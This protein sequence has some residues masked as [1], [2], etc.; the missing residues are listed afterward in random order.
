LSNSLSKAAQTTSKAPSTSTAKGK[1]KQKEV[2]SAST[3][4]RAKS[5]QKD[6]TETEDQ[7]VPPP[8]K[9]RQTKVNTEEP[10]PQAQKRNPKLT[11]QDGMSL[12]K[13]IAGAIQYRADREV[14]VAGIQ[15]LTAAEDRRRAEA[16]L[17]RAR[18]EEATEHLRIQLVELAIKA[19]SAGV[20][21]PNN[22]HVARVQQQTQADRADSPTT[23]QDISENVT[24]HVLESLLAAF[25]NQ[26]QKQ[27]QAEE[28]QAPGVGPAAPSAQPL[29][30]ETAIRLGLGH[31]VTSSDLRPDSHSNMLRSAARADPGVDLGGRGR[32]A[33]LVQEKFTALRDGPLLDPPADQPSRPAPLA[34]P[35]KISNIGIT[36]TDRRQA[37]MPILPDGRRALKMRATIRNM[38]DG[39]A[40]DQ[41][42]HRE[43]LFNWALEDKETM[44][45]H[46]KRRREVTLYMWKYI[47]G[48][49]P[50]LV[51]EEILWT[52]KTVEQYAGYYLT[53]RTHA[54]PGRKGKYILARTL[55]EWLTDLCWCITR[56]TRDENNFRCGLN[57]LVNG[58]Y[59]KL[60]SIAITLSRQ[61]QLARVPPKQKWINSEEVFMLVQLALEESEEQGRL[62]KLQVI[63]AMLLTFA[64]TARPSTLAPSDSS[65]AQ[66]GL[67]LKL[68]DIEHVRED[69]MKF[70]ST[71]TFTNFKGHNS[72]IVGKRLIFTLHATEKPEF[73]LLSNWCLILYQHWRGAFGFSSLEELI[74]YEGAQLRVLESKSKEPFF[75]TGLEGGR[76]LKLDKMQV[77]SAGALSQS[78]SLLGN[79]LGLGV[80][81]T[82]RGIRRGSSNRLGLKLGARIASNILAHGQRTSRTFDNFYSLN[83]E[84]L[85]VLPILLDEMPAAPDKDG[86]YQKARATQFFS[87][88]AVLSIV[89]R[90]ALENGLSSY[91]D[92]EPIRVPEYTAE[93]IA[94]CEEQENQWDE[95]VKSRQDLTVTYQSWV[96]ED[97]AAQDPIIRDRRWT[98]LRKRVEEIVQT[99]VA[100]RRQGGLISTALVQIAKR[101]AILSLPYRDPDEIA[102]IDDLSETSLNLYKAFRHHRYIHKLIRRRCDDRIF[103]RL[104]NA[105]PEKDTTAARRH[106]Q[107]LVRQAGQKPL[108]D[109]LA[110]NQKT[111]DQS[112]R[113]FHSHLTAN[114]H[115]QAESTIQEHINLLDIEEEEYNQAVGLMADFENLTEENL[116]LTPQC[117]PGPAG[118]K[119]ISLINHTRSQ[120]HQEM[121]KTQEDLDSGPARRKGKKKAAGS[122]EAEQ[123]TSLP[124]IPVHSECQD[125]DN[126]DDLAFFRK[127]NGHTKKGWDKGWCHVDQGAAPSVFKTV[128]AATVT[129]AL[130]RSV[131]SVIA[132]Q[133]KV[134]EKAKAALITGM[135]CERC[136]FLAENV[137]DLKRHTIQMHDPWTN[138]EQDSRTDQEGVFSCPKCGQTYPSLTHVIAHGLRHCPEKAWYLQ[139]R[140]SYAVTT[141]AATSDDADAL[142]TDLFK[143][144]KDGRAKVWTRL[145]E[146][147][148]EQWTSEVHKALQDGLTFDPAPLPDQLSPASRF[149]FSLE[150]QLST[151]EAVKAVLNQSDIKEDLE[152]LG[153]SL[154]NPQ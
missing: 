95:A 89:K 49:N 34:A 72:T 36:A 86:V 60:E 61:L 62:H 63:C 53:F 38:N 100:V 69:W 90:G 4:S 28:G 103:A 124:S 75:V 108:I 43:A 145:D 58:L 39:D 120:L 125:D 35:R 37:E 19:T 11:A 102:T 150:G 92:L 27:I 146:E 12:A 107:G 136:E 82:L 33:G 10:P 151:S 18:C 17:E 24:I 85:P 9:G 97:P 21:F 44:N 91:D 117:F 40:E 130:M 115:P 3:T 118:Q 140:S 5:K 56:F 83:T 16:D 67:Y 88:L 137:Y 47:L 116:G 112:A 123:T 64:T 101:A 45:A 113:D 93:D 133:L 78:I 29:L 41:N 114:I 46:S 111:P 71:V 127:E 54:T 31:R 87:S 2:D 51:A 121:R 20:Q 132:E 94:W 50:Y 141:A 55:V 126:G 152:K 138:L 105:E 68:G 66:Q 96:I 79:K 1:G 99:S 73:V 48:A 109:A 74:N 76:G 128:S 80:G 52:K 144:H 81:T 84:N 148:Q 142:A 65:Y 22:W 135:E 32:Q 23:G 134:Q 153:F 149:D 13:Q 106:A 143:Q 6:A 131:D 122:S 25:Q 42:R 30:E 119:L 110:F 26:R 57:L 154:D 8:K 147:Q 59:A 104:S 14:Q 15:A 7:A 70:T 77:T 139:M 98:T 129:E